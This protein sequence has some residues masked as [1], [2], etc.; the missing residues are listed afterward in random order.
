MSR[1]AARSASR[2]TAR[3]SRREHR[4]PAGTGP[5]TRAGREDA[6]A[7]P[8][9]ARDSESRLSNHRR[10]PAMMNRRSMLGAA[11][12]A[13]ALPLLAACAPTATRQSTGE[14]VDDATITAR[15]KARLVDDPVVK[16]REVKVETYRGV[17]Q[18]SGFVATAAEA[19]QAVELARGVPGVQS[20]KND[21]LIKPAP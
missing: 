10:N 18:L 9:V 2:A 15:V 14:Y 20:V 7:A 5:R 3:W 8:Q 16:A 1:S 21:I 17:V 6:A 4:D 11:A 13:L 19:R 12:A